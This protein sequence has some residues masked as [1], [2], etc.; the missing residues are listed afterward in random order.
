MRQRWLVLV[1]AALAAGCTR[2]QPPEVGFRGATVQG[3]SVQVALCLFNP[4]RFA[5]E[6]VSVDYR[7]RAD[8]KTLGSGR[9]AGTLRCAGRDSV[10]AEFPLELDYGAAMA[11]VLKGLKDTVTFGV[12]GEYRLR[13]P[14]G[15][16]A[17]RFEAARGVN[18]LEAIQ[19]VLEDTFGSGE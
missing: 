12:E 13:T 10:Q 3:D 2:V 1:L 14:I 16:Y 19:Q 8:E 7:V 11:A 18:L 9:R 6:M 5:V 15:P 4:N 17:G